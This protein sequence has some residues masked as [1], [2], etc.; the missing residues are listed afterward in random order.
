MKY[1]L[2]YP[3]LFSKKWKELKPKSQVRGEISFVEDFQ[4]FN[5][6]KKVIVIAFETVLDAWYVGK[7]FY[8]PCVNIF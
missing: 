5:E 3:N 6:V 7:L 1:N 8:T 2:P 4:N